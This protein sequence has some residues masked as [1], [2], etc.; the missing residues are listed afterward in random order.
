MNKEIV[1]GN[2]DLMQKIESLRLDCEALQSAINTILDSGMRE[3]T[4]LVLMQHY[5]K[6]PQK[7]IKTVM[8]GL[9][10]IE[11]EYFGND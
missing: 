1:M 3:K 11:I 9:H 10:D 8:D 6:L 7:T 2:E 5:T 4:I